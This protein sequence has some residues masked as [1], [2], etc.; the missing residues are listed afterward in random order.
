M[1]E[2]AMQF[3]VG[4]VVLAMVIIA[5]IIVLLI[6]EQ[7]FGGWAGD[8]TVNVTFDE[9]PG[10]SIGTPVRRSGIRI[11]EVTAIEFSEDGRVNVTLEISAQHQLHADETCQAR[12]SLLGDADIEFIGRDRTKPDDRWMND[13]KQIEGTAVADPLIML[14]ELQSDLTKAA[15]SIARAGDSFEEAGTSVNELAGNFNQLVLEN[16]QQ[17]NDLVANMAA[18]MDGIDKTAGALN[19]ILG[20]EETQQGL[21]EGLRDLPRVLA[22]AKK[23][24][25]GLQESVELINENAESLKGF[26]EP[27][28]RS[29]EDLVAKVESSIT[30]L[31][32]TMTQ[33]AGFGKALNSREGS[34]GQLVHDP[35][36]YQNLNRAAANIQRLTQQLAPIVH[37]VRV[38]TDKLARD[39]SRIGVRGVFRKPSGIK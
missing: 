3:R 21:Q 17:I 31:D 15:K 4:V 12:K 38:I 22:E 37:D 23:A 24:F 25:V 6:N 8:Y 7:W 30:Q 1:N 29:G 13:V 16:E 39:P 32:R 20:D 28:G 27:L 26:T 33:F 10:V 34:L 2:R 9:A 36:L 18:A 5:A 14:A 35:D 19:T 11:G